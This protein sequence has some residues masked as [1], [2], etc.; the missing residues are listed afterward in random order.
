MARKRKTAAPPAPARAE[1]DSVAN[2]AQ[3]DVVRAELH[4]E[5]DRI[6]DL[7]PVIAAERGARCWPAD[8]S[9]DRGGAGRRTVMI[10]PEHPELGSVEVT[11]VEAAA[12]VEDRAARWLRTL[13][14]MRVLVRWVDSSACKLTATAPIDPRTGKPANPDAEVCD[15]CHEPFVDREGARIPALTLRHG[16]TRA[17]VGTYHKR[18]CYFAA[19][20]LQRDSSGMPVTS[21]DVAEMAE[22]A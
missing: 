18:S 15:W 17:P 5:V 13:A 11:S 3:R 14:H 22:E 2:R 8:L 9:M 21:T 6:V 1:R 10:D 4:R 19:W 20:K 12:L 7:W 16:V